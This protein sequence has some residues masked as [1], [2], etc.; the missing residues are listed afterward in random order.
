MQVKNTVTRRKDLRPHT[1]ERAPMSG[2]LKN[3]KIPCKKK[4]KGCFKQPVPETLYAR[5][6]LNILLGKTKSNGFYSKCITSA[7]NHKN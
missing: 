1:S 2:A 4:R 7:R 6:Q 5:K 3:D